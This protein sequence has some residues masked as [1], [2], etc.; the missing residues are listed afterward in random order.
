MAHHIGSHRIPCLALRR[1]ALHANFIEHADPLVVFLSR[2][3]QNEPTSDRPLCFFS[4]QTPYRVL[5]YLSFIDIFVS[6]GSFSIP[7]RDDLAEHKWKR[8][9]SSMAFL[10]HMQMGSF[11]HECLR[12][13]VWE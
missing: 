13:H 10:V 4:F 12:E 2:V 1:T 11:P 5:S 3:E 9:Q 8:F 6:D 7:F